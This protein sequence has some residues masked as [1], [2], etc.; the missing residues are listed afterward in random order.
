[1]KDNWIPKSQ[2]R[3]QSFYNLA[4]LLLLET[5]FTFDSKQE[6]SEFTDLSIF[7][8]KLDLEL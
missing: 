6:L 4:F 7:L 1:M 5:L 2:L 8:H 3:R